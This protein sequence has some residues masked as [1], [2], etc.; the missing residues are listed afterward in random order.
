M[1]PIRKASNAF[2]AWCADNSPSAKLER[3]IA[4]GVI[5]VGVAALAS[6]G[7]APDVVQYLAIPTTMAILSPIQAEIG[8]ANGEPTESIKAEGTE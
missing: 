2:V 8:K 3:T 1:N 6:I 5:G 7:G 4:Q